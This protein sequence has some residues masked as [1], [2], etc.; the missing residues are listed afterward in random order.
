MYPRAPGGFENAGEGTETVS[1]VL[2]F[3]GIPKYSYLPVAILSFQGNFIILDK[4]AT[5]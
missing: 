2:T 3:I 4:I 5:R 1:G